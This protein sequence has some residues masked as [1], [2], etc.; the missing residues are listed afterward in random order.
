MVYLG[1]NACIVGRNVAKAE[2]V[3]KEMTTVR[4]GAK[5]IA[6][7]DVDV[8]KPAD[9]ERAVSECVK[10]LGG[11]DFVMYASYD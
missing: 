1:A 4:E 5:V 11:I 3:A 7:G 2:G 10:T 6:V 9:L 8:R